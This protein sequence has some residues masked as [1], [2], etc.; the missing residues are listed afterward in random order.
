MGNTTV[1]ESLPEFREYIISDRQEIDNI[2]WNAQVY[3]IQH[4]GDYERLLADI[5]AEI[6]KQA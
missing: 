6:L 3:Y 2:W 5:D 4:D 1:C